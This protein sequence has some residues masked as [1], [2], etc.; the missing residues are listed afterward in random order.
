M[1]AGTVGALVAAVPG[2]ID[3]LSLTEPRAVRIG[4]IHMALNLTIVGLFVA[5]LV[6][7]SIGYPS[8]AL[9]F[10]LSI[11]AVALLLVSGWFGW[12]L[13]YRE[14]VAISPEI[15]IRT[16]ERRGAA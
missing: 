11:I 8:L 15:E 3:Y 13:I 6:L 2:L 12:E 7:R 4:T 10:I 9:P 16:R 14:G 5:N 1:L